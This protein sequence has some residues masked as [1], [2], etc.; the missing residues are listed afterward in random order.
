MDDNDKLSKIPVS[1]LTREN[2]EAIRN[3]E[4]TESAPAEPRRR[5]NSNLPLIAAAVILFIGVAVALFFILRKP[6]EPGEKPEEPTTDVD[7]EV[8]WEPSAGSEDPV[9][10][11]IAHQEE[12]INSS[13]ATSTEKL[14]ARLAIVNS[15]TVN[16]E[17]DT[18]EALLNEIDRTNLTHRQL[19]NLYSV[20]SYLYQ[21]KGDT[22][23]HDEYAAL[24]E[25][26]LSEYWEEEATPETTG[27]N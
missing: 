27:E 18:A 25:Q 2:L 21:Q 26:V 19:F 16:E 3:G 4:R 1:D 24:V 17:Y 8:V 7:I 20:Y 22:A 11:Y 15:Y 14:E 9:G 13:E 6:A 23:A 5:K 10:E 12:I